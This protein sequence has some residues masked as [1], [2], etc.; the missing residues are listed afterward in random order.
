MK[1][2]PLSDSPCRLGYKEK[3]GLKNVISKIPE[4]IGFEIF[5]TT[6]ELLSETIAPYLRKMGLE[7][8]M[9]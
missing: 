3:T 9:V 1:G 2:K 7:K 6:P 8:K 4:E 5:Q